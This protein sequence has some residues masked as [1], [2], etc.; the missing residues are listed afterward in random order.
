MALRIRSTLAE[1][2]RVE[3][4]DKLR[5]AELAVLASVPSLDLTP[6]HLTPRHLA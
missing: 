4:R 5:S 6:L 2:R 3:L 1:L